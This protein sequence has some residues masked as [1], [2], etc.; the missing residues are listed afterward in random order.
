MQLH[1]EL[2]RLRSGPTVALRSSTLANFIIAE[3]AAQGLA[4]A[5]LGV[6]FYDRTTINSS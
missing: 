5:G 3:A 1:R 4:V 2:L 6:A